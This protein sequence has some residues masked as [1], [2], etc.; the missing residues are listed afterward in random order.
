M[1]ESLILFGDV[2]GGVSCIMFK[3]ATTSLFDVNIGKLNVLSSSMFLHEYH[4]DYSR[5]EKYII[6]V[7][8]PGLQG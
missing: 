4:I 3:E 6:A 8:K 1:N 2:G 7:V 5:R